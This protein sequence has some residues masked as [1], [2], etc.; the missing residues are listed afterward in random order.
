[1]TKSSSPNSKRSSKLRNSRSSRKISKT[2]LQKA[3]ET[4]RGVYANDF[5]RFLAFNIITHNT[6][7]E[8]ALTTLLPKEIADIMI[9]SLRKWSDFKIYSERVLLDNVLLPATNQLVFSLPKIKFSY[10]ESSI[11]LLGKLLIAIAI[12][13]HQPKRY[14]IKLR[15]DLKI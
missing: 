2:L 9:I 15:K 3:L 10:I 7:I 11:I 13:K 5:V 12:L 1:M 4:G 14:I 8:V 6:T